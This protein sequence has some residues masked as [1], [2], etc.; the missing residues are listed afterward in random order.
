MSFGDKVIDLFMP[1]KKERHQGN[2]GSIQIAGP[3]NVLTGFTEGLN[4][5][6]KETVDVKVDRPRMYEEFV[7][8]E[9]MIAHHDLAAAKQRMAHSLAV[10]NVVDAAL[11]DAG[12]KLG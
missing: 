1:T 3:V 10:M 4:D 12:I 2:R 7:A 6:T 11:A 5:G 8:F 9:A